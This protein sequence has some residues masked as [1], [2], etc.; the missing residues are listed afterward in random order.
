MKTTP[1][2]FI[3][4]FGLSITFLYAY[5][6]KVIEGPVYKVSIHS[7]RHLIDFTYLINCI[8][9]TFITMS[10][11]GYGDLYPKTTFGRLIGVLIAL[12]GNCLVSL[13]IISLNSAIEL[14][15]SEV[16]TVD[17]LA[18]LEWKKL[19]S[20]YTKQILK[21]TVLY[22]IYKKK[23]KKSCTVSSKNYFQRKHLR[24]KLRE[25]LGYRIMLQ[26][27][28]KRSIHSFNNNYNIP[29]ELDCINVKVS[30][31]DESIERLERRTKRISISL[32]LI[33]RFL[34]LADERK[35]STAS[36]F[37]G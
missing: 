18:R 14:N 10:T 5:S 24:E 4:V 25:A 31:L 3:L 12:I 36:R 34:N 30:F 22:N 1:V 2:R 37:D 6:I 16:L 13:M 9:Y 17:F 23:Y 19:F 28:L 29:D 33:K 35:E 15:E 21:H 20:N 11:V 26:K 8:W 27:D 32:K 7:Q